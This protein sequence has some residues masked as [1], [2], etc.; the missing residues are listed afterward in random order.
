[1]EYRQEFLRSF[2]VPFV[3]SAGMG[4][5][6]WGIYQGVYALLSSNVAALGVSVP[7]AAILYFVLEI[8]LGGM[9]EEEL[10]AIPKGYLLVKVARKCRLM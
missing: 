8:L 6:A 5:A 10:R 1:M 7:L 9:K 4:L 2:L 3:A